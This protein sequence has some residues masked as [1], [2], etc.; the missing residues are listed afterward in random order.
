MVTSFA[1]FRS[2]RQYFL[3]ALAFL[4]VFWKLP[5]I[6]DKKQ[7]LVWQRPPGGHVRSI[8]T[9]YNT[10]TDA[11]P[12]PASTKRRGQHPIIQLLVSYVYFET[13]E[14]KECER[15]N[16]RVNLAVF[17]KFAV[18]AS[19]ANVQF[20]FTFPGHRP[21]ANDY[22]KSL[23]ISENSETGKLIFDFFEAPGV[24]VHLHNASIAHPAADLCHHYHIIKSQ[25]DFGAVFD[26]AFT[27]NDG[28]RG[29]FVDD[30][31]AE[32]RPKSQMRFC[33]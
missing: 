15:L 31:K 26:F 21:S 24:H 33:V 4:F 28:V 9:P 12:R 6:S 25:L 5:T 30:N 20:H 3:C 1:R 32:V 7:R 11:Q 8:T 22:L 19:P 27:V 18:A 2:C 13:G 14:Q 23:G 17:L 10:T 16:K 29:P